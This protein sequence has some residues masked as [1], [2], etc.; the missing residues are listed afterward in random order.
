MTHGL[1]L[2]VLHDVRVDV[3]S[4]ADLRVPEDFH[5]D[6]GR[7]SGRREECG[8]AVPGVMQPDHAEAGGLGDAGE[9]LADI[10]RIF[11]AQR[12]VDSLSTEELLHHLRQDPESPWAEWGR[13]GLSARELGRL[14]RGFGVGPGNVRMADGTQR[15]GYTRNKFL[16]SWRRYC[17]TVHPVA[18]G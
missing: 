6:P 1:A 14:L 5:H 8:G 18:T 17:P 9:G 2:R 4:N 16:D 3:H 10:R 11:A 13:G 7:G 12:E 15:K